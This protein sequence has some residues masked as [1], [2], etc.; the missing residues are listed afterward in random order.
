MSVDQL[1]LIGALICFIIEF[2]NSA[3]PLLPAI[4][5]TALGLALWVLSALI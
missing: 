5:W 3:R 1:L 4:N 2:A